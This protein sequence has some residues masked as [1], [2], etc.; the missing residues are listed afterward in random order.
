MVQCCVP[1][2]TIAITWTKIGLSTVRS[3]KIHLGTFLQEIHQPLTTKMRLKLLISNFFQISQGTMIKRF[4]AQNTTTRWDS[5]ICASSHLYRLRANVTVNHVNMRDLFC[6]SYI[7]SLSFASRT[8]GQQ[9]A[10]P[11]ASE[12]SMSLSVSQPQTNH[13]KMQSS[14]N[15]VHNLGIHYTCFFQKGHKACYQIVT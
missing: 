3:I 14:A 4:T 10:C 6:Y 15:V 7:I 12:Y 8:L 2:G 11:S 9:Y 13:R 1:D 5:S